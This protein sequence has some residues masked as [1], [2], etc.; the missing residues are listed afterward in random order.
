MAEARAPR[1]LVGKVKPGDLLRRPNVTDGRKVLG[2]IEAAGGHVD[3][4]RKALG[5]VGQR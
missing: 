4:A 2:P 1:Q 3:L 5:L